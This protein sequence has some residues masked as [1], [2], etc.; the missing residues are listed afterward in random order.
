MAHE[1]FSNE[2]A[3]A[4]PDGPVE[5]AFRGLPV[6][7]SPEYLLHIQQCAPDAL[8][9]EA[10]VRAFRQLPPESNAAKATLQRLFR[11][12]G[13]LWDYI[14]PLVAYARRQARKAKRDSY[15][16]MLQDALL[17]ILTVLP[18]PR[19]ALA[20]RSW[21][22]YC[23]RELS[24]AWRERHGRRGERFPVEEPLEESGD[25][26]T[27]EPSTT[28]SIARRHPVL[29]SDGTAKIEA[30]AQRVVGE[31]PDDFVRAVASQ[32]WFAPKR[33]KVSGQ[34][35]AAE[36][37]AVPLTEM[38]PGKSR[39]QITRALRQADSQLAAALMAAPDLTW[40]GDLDGL[41]RRLRAGY[42]GG[43]DT[44]E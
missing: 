41:L 37:V 39:F 19:G 10:L 18:T 15:E 12:H 16:D 25:R 27:A 42:R 21:H 14:G 7:G 38:F 35:K 13:T 17:R 22:A 6:L 3:P 28:G 29:G 34:G 30:I 36:L 40:E 8:P 9:P 4:P 24:D 31:I 23:R 5:A 44:Q 32:A 33:P 1:E 26:Q 11:R 2:S 43:A 20:E